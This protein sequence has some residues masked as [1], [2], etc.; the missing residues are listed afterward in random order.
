MND[1][2][3]PLTIVCVDDD[4]QMRDFMPESIRDC[5]HG[6]IADIKVGSNRK[7]LVSLVEQHN[8]DIIITDRDMPEEN[9]GVKGI[10]DL[11]SRYSTPII[12]MTGRTPEEMQTSLN[13]LTGVYILFKPFNLE[14]LEKVMIE[15]Y[16]NI[17]NAR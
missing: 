10:K 15:A 9:A 17:F 14:K 2:E 7:E 13:E 1:S 4:E 8:P 11:R 16:P 6:R 12:L 3:R 5:L